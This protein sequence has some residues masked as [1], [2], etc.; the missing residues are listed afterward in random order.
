[1]PKMALERLV[2]TG[3]RT[4]VRVTET[5]MCNLTK[6]KILFTYKYF[7]VVLYV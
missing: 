4:G 3:V 2:D 1:M 7:V 5:F 6:H